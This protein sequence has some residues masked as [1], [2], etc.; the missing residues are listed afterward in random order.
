MGV[1]PLTSGQR[2]RMWQRREQDPLGLCPPWKLEILGLQPRRKGSRALETVRV[3]AQP[4]PRVRV[5]SH[6]RVSWFASHPAS[7]S[8]LRHLMVSSR[9]TL[10]SG[11]YF[12]SENKWCRPHRNLPAS[13]WQAGI[14]GQRH[15]TWPCLFV[16]LD[17]GLC[18]PVW[19]RTHSVAMEPIRVHYILRAGMAGES[20]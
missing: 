8:G 16:Y 18:S 11:S 7:G 10:T 15:H 2:V 5:S 4:D 9:E 1:R 20:L 14:K 13:A 12:S 6:L 19:T 3:P 17:G